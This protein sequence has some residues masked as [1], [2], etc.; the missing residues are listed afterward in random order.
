MENSNQ[1]VVN[2]YYMVITIFIYFI[3]ALS[4]KNKFGGAKISFYGI[5]LLI[6]RIGIRVID[7]ENTRP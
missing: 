7:F 6:L 3:M 5:I 1:R 4:L 2:C